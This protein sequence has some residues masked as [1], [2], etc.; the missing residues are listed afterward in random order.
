MLKSGMNCPSRSP[1]RAP[2]VSVLKEYGHGFLLG[3]Y[4]RGFNKVTIL[5][6]Y[7]L[8]LMDEPCDRVRGANIITKLDLKAGYNP[9][10]IK[11][12]NQWKTTFCP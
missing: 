11:K 2:I 7:W 9:I 3:F 1:A 8:P 6:R 12:G 10:R 5:I 4:Y